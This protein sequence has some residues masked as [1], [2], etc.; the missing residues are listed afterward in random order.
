MHSRIIYIILILVVSAICSVNKIFAATPNW[1]PQTTTALPEITTL[2]PKVQNDQDDFAAKVS[3]LYNQAET[4][5]ER[6]DLMRAITL[7]REVIQL[8][9]DIFEPKFQCAMACLATRQATLLPEAISLLQAAIKI[10]PDFARGHLALANALYQQENSDPLLTEQAVQ[11]ALKLDATLRPAQELLVELLLKRQAYR[12]AETALTALVATTADKQHYL[13]LGLAQQ[14]QQRFD[15]ALQSFT[16][17][18]T[19]DPQ[20]AEAYYQRARIYLQK[21]QFPAAIKDLEQAYQLRAQA[22]TGLLLAETYLK[23]NQREAARGLAEKL[24]P[25][26]S[27]DLRPAITE[28]LASLGANNEAIAQF[29]KQL[30]ADPQNLTF[31]TRLGELYLDVDPSKSQEYWRRALAVRSTAEN[32]AGLGS[33]LLKGKQFEEAVTTFEKALAQ[34]D[35]LYEPHAGLALALFKLERFAPAAEQF[36]W[37]TRARPENSINLYFLAICFD[38]LGDYERAQLGYQ[39]FLKQ[40]NP[41]TYQLEIDKVNLRL[42]ILR[43]QLEKQKKK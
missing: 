11:E 7:Y 25:A 1:L 34:N 28:L 8:A 17:A 22:E 19:Q 39:L 23:A 20:F 29:E 27:A 32:L 21:Q 2:S 16:Q 9:P 43:R 41:T 36:I 10:R 42:P 14:A 5:F 4:A 37:I 18:L 13:L 6:G 15:P 31:L 33:A 26:A 35:K 40:A 3:A 30:A 12:E 38:R 24:L